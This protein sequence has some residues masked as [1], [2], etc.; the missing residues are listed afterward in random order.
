MAK[1]MKLSATEWEKIF[2]SLIFDRRLVFRKSEANL[3]QY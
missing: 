1:E 3:T 2:S